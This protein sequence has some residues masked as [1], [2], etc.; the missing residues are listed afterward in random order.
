MVN[1]Y[2]Q[3]SSR[4]ASLDFN[5]KICYIM[6]E[7]KWLSHGHQRCGGG[8]RGRKRSRILYTFKLISLYHDPLSVSAGLLAAHSLCSHHSVDLLIKLS[9]PSWDQD[10]CTQ[11]FQVDIFFYT[12]IIT[13][14]FFC[15]AFIFP[16]L[17]KCLKRLQLDEP[18]L[19]SQMM[20]P[21]TTLYKFSPI[22]LFF[23][24][25]YLFII[26]LFLQPCHIFPCLL[27]SK[28]LPP[29]TVCSHPLIHSS[30]SI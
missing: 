18:D 26:Y 9:L 22:Y 14:N 23:I 30:V 1:K 20:I 21:P 10:F 3:S 27:S 5:Y 4:Q 28:S 2:F 24:W 6:A 16:L 7:G 25:I 19:Y 12:Q 8:N 13:T 29:P 11:A 15:Y 17:L